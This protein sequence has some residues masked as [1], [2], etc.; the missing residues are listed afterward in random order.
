MYDPRRYALQL[1]AVILGGNMSSRLFISVRERN[2]LGY[3][4]HTS[5]DTAT[6]IGIS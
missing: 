4:I 5:L 3:Y 2:G 1:I 6:D